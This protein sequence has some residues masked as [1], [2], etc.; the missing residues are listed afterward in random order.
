M[1]G[2]YRQATYHVASS[3]PL[4]QGQ[5]LIAMRL[6]KIPHGSAN[7]PTYYLYQQAISWELLRVEYYTRCNRPEIASDAAAR[8]K[9]YTERYN[10]LPETGHL[11]NRSLP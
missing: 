7:E 6:N 2:I 10:E 4:L 1:G 11:F 3:S 8:A 9:H 5:P